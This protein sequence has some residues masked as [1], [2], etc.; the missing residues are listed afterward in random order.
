MRLLDQPDRHCGTC[1]RR[2]FAPDRP[3]QWHFAWK[4]QT[5]IITPATIEIP[6]QACSPER[7]SILVIDTGIKILTHDPKWHQR[8]NLLLL[9]QE[10]CGSCQ[11]HLRA[12]REFSARSFVCVLHAGTLC[13]PRRYLVHM[14]SESGFT[15]QS[16][17]L[18]P[19][20]Y[21]PGRFRG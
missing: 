13:K 2:Y 8:S 19:A 10:V 16:S 20:S 5:P 21:L 6:K 17:G 14:A 4:V 15:T 18:L 7:V 3:G 9:L 11:S 12:G 1:Q